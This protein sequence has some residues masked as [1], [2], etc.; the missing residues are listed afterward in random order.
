[1]SIHLAWNFIKGKRRLLDN[2]V[3]GSDDRL[4]QL[5][6]VMGGFYSMV[7]SPLQHWRDRG[8]GPEAAGFCEIPLNLGAVTQ[9]RIFRYAVHKHYMFSTGCGGAVDKY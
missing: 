9:S 2:V 1:M 6:A 7:E 4:K 5:A 3:D 8:L